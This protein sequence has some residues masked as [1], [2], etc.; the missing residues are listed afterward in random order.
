MVGINLEVGTIY[1]RAKIGKD[2]T[3]SFDRDELRD[4]RKLHKNRTARWVFESERGG[5]M[6]MDTPARV[7]KEAAELAQIPENLAHPH[8][9]RHAAGYFLIT[10]APTARR[11]SCARRLGYQ[12]KRYEPQAWSADLGVQTN[13]GPACIPL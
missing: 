13:I 2:S 10:G 9:L 7:I 8:A 6:S 11:T 4:L 12:Q 3:Y 5:H 1:G